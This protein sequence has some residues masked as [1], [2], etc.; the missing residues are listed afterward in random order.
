M[1]MAASVVEGDC[2]NVYVG[3]TWSH[4]TLRTGMTNAL[5]HLA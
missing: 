5:V 3:L 4:A 1:A 2:S